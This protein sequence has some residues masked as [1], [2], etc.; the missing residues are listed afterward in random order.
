VAARIANK[1]VVADALAKLR[2]RLFVPPKALFPE[3]AAT[4]EVLDRL[5]GSA[6]S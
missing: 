4:E 5:A 3:F 2:S 1:V 6:D